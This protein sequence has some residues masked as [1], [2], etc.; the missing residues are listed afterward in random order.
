MFGGRAA[1]LT[2]SV[3]SG[4]LRASRADFGEMAA[5]ATDDTRTAAEVGLKKDDQQSGEKNRRKNGRT[6]WESGSSSNSATAMVET[7]SG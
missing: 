3:R 5:A 4:A 1:E 6:I 2:T 7:A